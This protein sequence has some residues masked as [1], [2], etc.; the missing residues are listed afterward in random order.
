[1][2]RDA[3]MTAEQ[4]EQTAG[5]GFERLLS[6]QEATEVLG[7]GA[8]PNPKGSLRW[9]MRTRK[10][11]YV[12]LARGIHGFRPADLTAFI[13]ANRVPAAGEKAHGD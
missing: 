5:P 1:M 6:E 7:L 2:S 10:L 9:L 13:Q 3:K 11:A 4:M 8:R 12:R